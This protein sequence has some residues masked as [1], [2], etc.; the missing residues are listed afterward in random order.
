MMP[1]LWILAATVA[2]PSPTDARIIVAVGNNLGT[3]ADEPLDYAEEDARR[4]RQLMV[5]IGGVAPDRAYIVL[6]EDVSGVR[7]ALYEARGRLQELA[8]ERRASLIVFVSAHADQDALH[9]AGTKLAISELRDI[10]GTSAAD[11]KLTVIDACQTPAASKTKG[12]RPVPEVKIAFQAPSRVGGD[13]FLTSASPGEPA[14]ERAF[15][16]GAL[17]SHHFFTGLRGAADIDRDRAVSLEEAYGYAFRRTAAAAA[18]GG[19]PQHPS[20]AID[21]EGFGSWVLTRPGDHHSSL[22]LDQGIEGTIWVANRKDELVA[23]VSK[24][25]AEVMRLA[26][27]AGWYRVVRPQGTS[28]AVA[29]VNLGWGGEQRLAPEDFVRVR[30]S[31]AKLRGHQPIKARPWLFTAGYI[32]GANPLPGPSLEHLAIVRL[33][34]SFGAWQGR[35]QLIGTTNAFDTIRGRIRTWAMGLGIGATYTLPI[36]WLDFGLGVE[37]S[38]T[39]VHQVFTR[40]EEESI[41]RVFDTTVPDRA[42]WVMSGTAVSYLAIPL[43]DRLWIQLELAAGGA[44]VPTTDGVEINA[45]ARGAILAGISL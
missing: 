40:D 10:V 19:A 30:M 41:E 9:L 38:A 15:L 20:F 8:S 5:E 35:G 32:L 42:D 44:R 1:V 29:D 14:Q 6:G 21:M 37:L 26:L 27:A 16:R 2:A 13:A 3:G 17:F 45:I 28:A 18:F 23:E 11:L 31:R 4:F 24:T 25:S 43:S 12:G 36:A 7:K 39:R 34:R 22:V 33:Q